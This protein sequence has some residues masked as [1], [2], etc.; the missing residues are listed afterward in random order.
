MND[1]LRFLVDAATAVAGVYRTVA[2]ARSPL[3]LPG[4]VAL[5]TW[6]APTLALASLISL[7]ALSGVAVASLAG[8]L[9][10]L[11]LAALILDAVFGVAFE[12]A[13]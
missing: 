3:R 13:G 6:L 9:T 5:P 12:L 8:L 10:S 11:L 1:P 4:G 7:L 2:F